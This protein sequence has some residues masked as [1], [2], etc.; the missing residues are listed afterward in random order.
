[1]RS[2]K[3]CLTPDEDSSPRRPLKK[4]PSPTINTKAALDDIIDIFSQPLK[5]QQELD[6]EASS[7]EDESD[8]TSIT[9]RSFGNQSDVEEKIVAGADDHAPTS[10]ADKQD[11]LMDEVSVIE[12]SKE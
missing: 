6:E 2:C 7:S 1:V 3:R 9:S 11:E 5:S 10:L 4:R 8:A 12:I